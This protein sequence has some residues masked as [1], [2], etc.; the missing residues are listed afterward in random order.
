MWFQ[1]RWIYTFLHVLLQTNYGCGR[2]EDFGFSF[3][4]PFIYE[5]KKINKFLCNHAYFKYMF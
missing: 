5:G 3:I 1:Q 4:N 2:V